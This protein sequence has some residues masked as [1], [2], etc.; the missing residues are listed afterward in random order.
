M[1]NFTFRKYFCGTLGN[2][3]RLYGKHW[4]TSAMINF[5]KELPQNTTVIRSATTEQYTKGS[6]DSAIYVGSLSIDTNG[7]Q[8]ITMN[9]NALLF[10]VIN[11][12]GQ[13]WTIMDNNRQQWSK[14]RNAMYMHL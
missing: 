2:H 14:I 11:C 12:N 1:N 8:F 13:Q 9:N 10:I 7:Q 6:N 3:C 5:T 4:E